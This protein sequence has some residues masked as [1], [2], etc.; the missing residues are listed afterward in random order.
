MDILIYLMIL[1]F[2]FWDKDWHYGTVISVR[3][4][5]VCPNGWGGQRGYTWDEVEATEP[6]EPKRKV[7]FLT[8]RFF[9]WLYTHDY[10]PEVRWVTFDPKIW[11]LMINIQKYF[12]HL[13]IIQYDSSEGRHWTEHYFLCLKPTK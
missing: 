5:K 12:W 4:L 8:L 6:T 10:M 1:H 11:V 13:R 9:F 7:F 3:P 2:C